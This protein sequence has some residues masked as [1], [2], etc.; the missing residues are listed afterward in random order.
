MA[1]GREGGS[2]VKPLTVGVGHAPLVARRRPVHGHDAPDLCRRTA[3]VTLGVGGLP[4]CGRRAHPGPAG[5]PRVQAGRR[6]GRRCPGTSARLAARSSRAR[7][8]RPGVPPTRPVSALRAGGVCRDAAGRG[9]FRRGGDGC[10]H[11]PMERGLP[12]QLLWRIAQP[13]TWALCKASGLS[14]HLLAAQCGVP[15]EHNRASP[16]PAWQPQDAF[17]GVRGGRASARLP[18]HI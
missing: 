2:I 1:E 13:L 12:M 9:S 15:P 14:S 4:S 7:A 8:P 5:P 16:P 10:W 11:S 3:R 6:P 17:S 18:G